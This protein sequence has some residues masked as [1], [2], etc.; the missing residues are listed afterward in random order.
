[1]KEYLFEDICVTQR[2]LFHVLRILLAQFFIVI[3]PSVSWLLGNNPGSLSRALNRDNSLSNPYEFNDCKK[4]QSLR[5][6]K[7]GRVDLKFT[8]VI[9]IV[10]PFRTV[11]AAVAGIGIINI[12]RADGAFSTEAAVDQVRM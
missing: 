11:K 1:M 6:F 2:Q 12:L 4:I 3:C 8:S 5:M 9:L 7:N 10:C